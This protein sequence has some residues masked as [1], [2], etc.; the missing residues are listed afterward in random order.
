[1]PSEPG[2]GSFTRSPRGGIRLWEGRWPAVDQPKGQ[3]E[4]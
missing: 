1:M 4:G 2:T 3:K